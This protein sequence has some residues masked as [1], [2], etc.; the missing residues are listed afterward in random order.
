MKKWMLPAAGL[1]LCAWTMQAGAQTCAAP[2]P[3]MA[4]LWAN[5]GDTCTAS[6]PLPNLGGI[7]VSTQND[8]VYSYVATGAEKFTIINSGGFAGSDATVLLL[9]QCTQTASLLAY[10]MPGLP[11]DTSGVTTPGNT[12]FVVV[13]GDPGGTPNGC[14]QYHMTVQ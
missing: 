2:L 8:I 7:F 10:G 9:P 11:M 5:A 1:L 3:L 14:G 6:N 4:G 12:Y 13:T